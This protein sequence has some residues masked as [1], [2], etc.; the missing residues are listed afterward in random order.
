MAKESKE[1]RGAGRDDMGKRKS[2]RGKVEE[3]NVQR[4][5]EV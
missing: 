2:E 1:Q 3:S 4:K 5:A